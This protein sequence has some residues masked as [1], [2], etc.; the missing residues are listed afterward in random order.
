MQRCIS[1]DDTNAC[2]TRE[3]QALGNHLGPDQYVS[4]SRSEL[5]NHFWKGIFVG[6]RI[7]VHP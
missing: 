6:Y 2:H 4:L 7:S 3:I 5:L 1:R